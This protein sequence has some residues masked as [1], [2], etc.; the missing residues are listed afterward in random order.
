MDLNKIKDVAR[1]NR[2]KIEDGAGKVIDGKLEGDK[3]QKAKDGVNQGLDKV[4]G[5]D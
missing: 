3:A 1:Q 5:E 4:L 2:D